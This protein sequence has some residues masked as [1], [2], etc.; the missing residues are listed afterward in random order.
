VQRQLG[1]PTIY[2]THDQAEAMAVGDRIAVLNE[3]RLQQVGTPDEVYHLPA[4]RFVANFIG[5]QGMNWIEGEFDEHKG[6]EGLI[7]DGVSVVIPSAYWPKDVLIDGP[8]V[9]GIRP[10]DVEVMP[11]GSSSQPH[12]V[13]QLIST[14]TIGDTTYFEVELAIHDSLPATV[15]EPTSMMIRAP[16]QSTTSALKPGDRVQARFHLDRIHWF[17]NEESGKRLN[18][19]NPEPRTLNPSGQARCL[20]HGANDHE[21]C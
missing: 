20:S 15:A 10:E 18:H 9:A 6:A 7:G 1:V 21:P 3:G 2:V 12:A 11:A 19:L 17:G 4:N 13:G 14:E 5:P 16:N 8:V